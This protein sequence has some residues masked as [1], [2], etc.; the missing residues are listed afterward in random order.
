MTLVEHVLLQARSGLSDIDRDRDRAMTFMVRYGGSG[1][2]DA[3]LADLEA[4]RARHVLLLQ[5]LEALRQQN[6]PALLCEVRPTRMLKA[7]LRQAD[8]GVAAGGR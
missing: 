2:L 4:E 3:W 1:A 8:R 5:G 7:S 6:H